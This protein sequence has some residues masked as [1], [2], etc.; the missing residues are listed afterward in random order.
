MFEDDFNDAEGGG[1]ASSGKIF[2]GNP[3]F[4]ADQKSVEKLFRPFG[5]IIGVNLREERAIGRPK[6]FGFVTFRN[7]SCVGRAIQE[8]NGA[9]LDDR[10]LTVNHADKMGTKTLHTLPICISHY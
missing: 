3:P 8:M 6:R 4:S 5:G 1:P 10:R 2:L 7:A 9:A